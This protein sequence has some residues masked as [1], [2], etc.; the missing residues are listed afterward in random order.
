MVSESKCHRNIM[1]A[2]SCMQTGQTRS[3]KYIN[4]CIRVERR[5]QLGRSM[6]HHS[7]QMMGVYR[8]SKMIQFTKQRTWK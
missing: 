2:Y 1:Y 6:T 3:N 5:K 7:Y 4:V 8:W